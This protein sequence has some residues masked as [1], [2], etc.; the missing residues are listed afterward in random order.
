MLVLVVLGP[1]VADVTANGASR[2]AL[3]A[4]LVEHHSVD[5]SPYG[6]VLGV[7]KAIVGGR[8]R[9]DKAPGQPLLAVPAYALERAVGA[10][11]YLRPRVTGNLTVWWL[12][13]TTSVLPFAL[14]CALVFCWLFDHDPAGAFGA[15]MALAGGT[16]FLAFA[17]QL[18]GHSLAAL[19]AFGAWMV[20]R[21]AAPSPSRAAL[22]G[23]L[24]GAAVLVEYQAALAALAVLGWVVVRH[25]VRIRSFVVGALP[26]AIAFGAYHWVAFG[27]PW[28]LPYAYFAP[29]LARRGVAGGGVGA[30]GLHSAAEALVGRHGLVT[31]AP[32]VVVAL[33]SVARRARD[34]A[35]A[36]RREARFGAAVAAAFI[37]FAA[38]WSGSLDLEVPGPRYVI[39]GLAFLGGAVLVARRAAPLVVAVT[40]AFGAVTGLLGVVTPHL[41]SVGTVPMVEYLRQLRSG[42][43]IPTVWTMAFGTVLGWSVYAASVVV[44]AVWVRRRV[45][46]AVTA[47]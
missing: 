42:Q 25:R 46:I 24:A 10:E 4:A 18:Y 12:T 28:R 43:T 21:R 9:S 33:W 1:F 13:L 3:T 38:M 41:V 29:D 31:I 11:S 5:I 7:D 26:P 16:L 35:P 34:E 47:A 30:A 20:V 2:A 36:L 39:P 27:A 32:L 45:Q 23:F 6:R 40:A 37:A 22:A 44:A 8:L 15:T 17:P 19:C 14:L